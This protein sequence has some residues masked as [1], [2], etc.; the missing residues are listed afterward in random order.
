MSLA[1]PLEVVAV[2]LA[3]LSECTTTRPAGFLRQTAMSI[4]KHGGQVYTKM[5][6][7]SR[8][9]TL[10]PIIAAK[11]ELDSVVFSDS[12]SAYDVLDISGF[13]H[14]WINHQKAFVGAPGSHI[15]GKENFRSQAKRHLRRSSS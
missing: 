9:T 13:R 7:D 8:R 12:F 11:V 5:I 4:L 3:A 10:I 6:L 14:H 15:N 2:V 1:K